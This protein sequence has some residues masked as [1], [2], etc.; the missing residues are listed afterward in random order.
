MLVSDRVSLRVPPKSPARPK[1]A[2]PAERVELSPLSR[3]TSCP[4][5]KGKAFR[6]L[7]EQ[8]ACA[9]GGG[10]ALAPAAL[11]LEEFR[12]GLCP[13]LAQATQNTD[14]SALGALSQ[15]L[16]EARL[17]PVQF[18]DQAAAQ[19]GPSF[20]VGDVRVEAR[21]EAVQQILVDTAA[22]PDEGKP[23]GKSS[24]QKETLG[25]LLGHESVFFADGQ[26][27]KT[28]R[29]L[30]QPHFTGNRVLNDK[31]HGEIRET[32]NRHLDSW[33]AEEDLGIR[34]KELTLDAA[35]HHMF[36][37][38][39]A[40]EEL[41]QAARLFER[42]GAQARDLLYGREGHAADLKPQLDR[43]ADR[44]LQGDGEMLQGLKATLT[45]PQ[46]LRDEVLS[47]S[48][49]GH[50]TTANLL[51]WA[52]ADASRSPERLAEIRQELDAE[53]KP[54]GGY[55]ATLKLDATRDLIHDTFG[56]H[57]PNYLLLR[58]A[59]QDVEVGGETIEAGTQVLLPLAVANRVAESESGDGSGKV[60]SFGSGRRVCMGQV[61]ARLEAAVV[62]STILDRFDLEPVN[63]EAPKPLTDFS[64]GPSD[65]RY[66]LRPR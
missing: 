60:F 57:P 46:K 36:G 47:M 50:E 10:A 38:Q 40:P 44:L 17:D 6:S 41:N 52:L 5:G 55:D 27:W 45:D 53:L 20:Q 33:G 49:L 15:A 22:R 25:S 30:M 16:Q 3:H 2:A 18:F 61:F 32:V 56:E 64:Q 42:V 39:L 48:L 14:M 63:P 23:F 34:L 7:G 12:Q 37:V 54:D 43:L 11:Q 28:R 1:G 65:N 26:E 51:A 4:T 8:A 13:Y 9:A 35:L 66:R 24:L 59:R 29:E 19:F 21:P 62:L 31:V 58:E